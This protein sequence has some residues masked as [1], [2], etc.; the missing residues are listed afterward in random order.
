MISDKVFNSIIQLDEFCSKIKMKVHNEENIY[1]FIKDS[2]DSIDL[3]TN[4]DVLCRYGI[5]CINIIDV[6]GTLLQDYAVGII[7][8]FEIVEKCKEPVIVLNKDEQY[9]EKKEK[10]P[11]DNTYTYR[12]KRKDWQ[13][14]VESCQYVTGNM[15]TLGDRYFLVTPAY[16]GDE[17]Y[18]DDFT[19]IDKDTIEPVIDEKKELLIKVHSEL[20]DLSD[21]TT[22]EELAALCDAC[23]YDYD[24]LSEWNK[25]CKLQTQGSIISSNFARA[26]AE[27]YYEDNALIDYA[28]KYK[29][30][31]NEPPVKTNKSKISDRAISDR[32]L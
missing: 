31:M 15:V 12:A 7:Q 4:N 26:L 17:L 11:M 18:I 20:T 5:S 16:G 24:T 22:D 21:A 6:I 9:N 19:E 27:N 13:E 32:E 2:D 28:K 3:Y 14:W 30:F 25:E 29:E 8:D 1:K 10:Q 23:D